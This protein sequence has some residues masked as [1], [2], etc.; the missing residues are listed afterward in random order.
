MFSN[1]IRNS[2]VRQQNHAQ[3]IHQTSK[4]SFLDHSLMNIILSNVH[5]FQNHQPLLHITSHYEFDLGGGSGGGAT[6]SPTAAVGGSGIRNQ[7]LQRASSFKRAGAKASVMQSKKREKRPQSAAA[8]GDQ[9]APARLPG[10]GNVAD[11]ITITNASASL[12]HSL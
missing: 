5:H 11:S 4:V 10:T 3:F 1:L 9:G 8:E 6:P 2:L 12:Q 7:T